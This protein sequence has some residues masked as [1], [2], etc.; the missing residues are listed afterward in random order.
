VNLSFEK[1]EVYWYIE[2]SNILKATKAS[3]DTVL[4]IYL[5]KQTKYFESTE[6][7]IENL[8]ATQLK[9]M[10]SALEERLDKINSIIYL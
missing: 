3:F 4:K 10:H 9:L 7:V 2:M 5:K 1:K 6:V 8:E